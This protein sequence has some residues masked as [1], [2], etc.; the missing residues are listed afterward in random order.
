MAVQ[1]GF[2]TG[3]LGR[4]EFQVKSSLRSSPLI[5]LFILAAAIF[6]V[7]G[8][9]LS[10]AQAEDSEYALRI[11]V[12]D[13]VR[14]SDGKTDNQPVPGVEVTVTDSSGIVVETGT[15]DA[16][17][18]LIISVPTRAD[19]TVSLNE[20]TLP[21]GEK[22]DSRTP[23]IQNVLTDSFVTKTKVI[24]YFTGE[25]QNVSQ[26]GFERVAQRFSDGIRLGLILAMC[27]V[28]LSLIFGTTG[29]T[30]FAHGEMVTF[31]GIM[32]FVFNVTGL[33][34]LGFLGFIPGIRD[35]GTFH[36]FWAAPIG[37][38]L[39]GGFGW[40]LNKGIFGPLRRRG[41]GLVTQMVLTVGLS[42]A[43]RNFF[44][45]RFEGRTRPFADFSLQKAWDL[46]PINITPRDFT[47]SILC[48]IILVVTALGLRFTR[49]GKATRAVSD[50]PDLASATG[51]D[52]EKVIRLVWI[53]GG[54]LAAAGGIFRGLDEQVS[55]DMGGRLLFLLFAGIT[56]GG[57]G[58]A[59]GALVGGFV[60]GI[61]VEVSSLVV[62]TELKTAPALIILI[63]VLLLRPQGILG[64]AQ[65]VG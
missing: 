18:V 7:L 63:L 13:Q 64:R 47:V 17:G 55:F 10:P 4:V 30:N 50:N 56:L 21:S 25:S 41:V 60:I 19:Y 29:L 45:S 39:G 24:T 40:A 2:G 35:D 48:L 42:I 11:Q 33:T 57:L 36:I 43:L 20:A 32:A 53:L 28:G 59:F 23:A 5:R 62:P 6:S 38:I 26:S 3:F 1:D 31:G 54:C 27:S 52:S 44:L 49:L 51:I 12:K 14:T 61:L 15:T 65:R 16:E 37:I 46:G 9:A 34:F 58:S 22:L 8:F